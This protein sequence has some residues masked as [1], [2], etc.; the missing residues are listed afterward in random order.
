MLSR[1]RVELMQTVNSVLGRRNHRTHYFPLHHLRYAPPNL[2][3]FKL[4]IKRMHTQALFPPPGKNL[5]MSTYVKNEIMESLYTCTC[6]AL[7]GL[8][9]LVL[10]ESQ[11]LKTYEF[12]MLLLATISLHMLTFRLMITMVADFAH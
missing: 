4:L 7:R 11:G 9:T 5:G 10:Q 3:L 2:V 6:I 12:D 8:L 1:G